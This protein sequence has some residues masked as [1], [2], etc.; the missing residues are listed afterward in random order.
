M[1]TLDELVVEL[2]A[3]IADF[4][5]SLK[6]ASDSTK[7]ETSVMTRAFEVFAGSIASDLVL[8]GFDTVRNA[9]T[10]LFNTF[11]VE[12]V[13][14]AQSQED[15][16]NALN[17]S[18]IVSGKYTD[19]TSR[20]L[21]E[22]ASQLQATSKYGDETILKASGL[23]QSL[24]RL[25]QEGLKKA[26]ASAL[27][28]SAA[29]GIDLQTAAQLVGKAAAGQ[30]SALTR[31]GISIQEGS[32]KA[33][34]FQK[35]LDGL[36]SR[37]GGAAQSQVQTYSGAVAQL[38]NSYGDALEE[39]GNA[40]IKNQTLINVI[41]SA[42]GIIEELTGGIKGNQSA[43]SDLISKGIIFTIEGLSTLVSIGEAAYITMLKMARGAVEAQG[44][45][46]AFTDAIT[47][48]LTDAGKRAEESAEEFNS[49]DSKISDLE[50]GNTVF[51]GINER[52]YQLKAAAESGFGKMADG[53]DKSAAALRGA[54]AATRELTEEQ[55]KLVE[56]AQKI[57]DKDAEGGSNKAKQLEHE[58][59]LLRGA[60]EQKLALHGDL[61]TAISE[62]EAE[63]KELKAQEAEKEIEDLVARNDL[64]LQLDAEKNAGI[65]AQNRDRISQLS[66]M[67]D[68]S[69]VKSLKRQLKDKQ[70]RQKVEDS[71]LQGTSSFL[72][73]TMALSKGHSKELFEFAKA[74]ATATA[75]IEGI[76]AVQR[77]LANPPG[78]PFSIP[79]ALAAGAKAATNVAAIQST[80]F[81]RGVDSVPGIGSRDIVPAALMPGEIVGSKTQNK[82][83]D[84]VIDAFE[85]MLGQGGFGGSGVSV[86][87]RMKDGLMDFI[88]AELVK[89]G[90]LATTSIAA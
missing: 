74:A 49:L 61:Q 53:G 35:V 18:L 30:V 22:F 3:D 84:R 39:I 76:V 44:A 65:I 2:R 55:Q 1:P 10:G 64:L 17:Q 5:K 52:L 72:S 20:S 46:S 8:R 25:D 12:G 56:G 7:K 50:S 24:G 59:E 89:R 90:R 43:F 34:T 31:Y 71:M 87:I 40:I 4:K 9:A 62:R 41:A 37:F 28:L 82:K 60:N 83:L 19:Q 15:A 42:K 11:V 33:E 69:S 63:L 85:Y 38:K 86:E 47:F 6:E 79:Q 23:I 58:L 29:L 36:S 77:A 66:V 70:D 80:G 57:L 75:I 51:D 13:S 14:A 88:E 78:P 54:A 32:S 81:A 68:E 26:T 21:Q 67:E 45:I 73:S 16:I 27:D 48:G